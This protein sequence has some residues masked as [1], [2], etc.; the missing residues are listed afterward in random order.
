M[1]VKWDVPDYVGTKP[2]SYTVTL[3]G[4]GG[5]SVT[6]ETSGNSL[7]FPIDNSATGDGTSY[8]ATVK[9]KNRAGEGQPSAASNAA[10][11]WGDP[12]APTVSLSV[13]K[14]NTLKATLT[15]GNMHNAGCS[16]VE[17]SGAISMSAPCG[18]HTV[19]DT[20]SRDQWYEELSVKATVNPQ[21]SGAKPA[22]A[23]SNK[24]TP[25]YKIQPPKNLQVT[26]KGDECS[27]SVGG[28]GE[29]D[30]LSI[31]ANGQEYRG[32]GDSAAATYRINPWETCGTVSATQSFKG[33][34]SEAIIFD[35]KG[36]VYKTPAKIEPPTLAWSTTDRNRIT[37]SG[38]S[39]NLY[40]QS[41]TVLVAFSTT[42]G[43]PTGGSDWNVTWSTASRQGYI[44][45]SS[46]RID[47]EKLYWYISVTGADSALNTADDIREVQGMRKPAEGSGTVTEGVDPS[48]IRR[49]SFGSMPSISTLASN[50]P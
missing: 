26:L 32:N 25:Q 5:G 16:S 28:N 29:H 7:V 15:L 12:D 27:V 13:I 21:Q 4:S 9:G 33:H 38:G 1:T 14:G 24:V 50:R 19:T 45:I 39:V 6:K 23:D 36:L 40:G 42:S 49:R 47:T 34:S 46:F 18:T 35:G 37:V 10:T 8:T 44:D 22:S 2:D 11:P 17:L 20:I 31:F 48:R 30:G 43:K 41:A 3:T